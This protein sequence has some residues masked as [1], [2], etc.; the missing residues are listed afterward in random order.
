MWRNDH[1]TLFCHGDKI[2]TRDRNYLRF[3]KLA[4]NPLTR[5]VLKVIPY[6][7]SAAAGLKRDLKQTNLEFRKHLPRTEIVQFA[8]RAFS[9]GV[10]TI[11]V[12]HFHQQFRIEG[13]DGNMLVILPAWM[14]N[15]QVA[16]V[17]P[18][19]GSI[20]IDTWDRLIPFQRG[21]G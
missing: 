7:P 6:G 15:G 2:N 5:F 16:R 20:R 14:D 13:K 11:F 10:K 8:E 9:D 19:D 4:K 3:R 21:N 1:D 18:L 17:D 12:G